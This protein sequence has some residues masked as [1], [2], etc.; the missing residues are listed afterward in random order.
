MRARIDGE[1]HDTRCRPKLDPQ[2]ANT[3]SKWWSTALTC[4]PSRAASGRILRDRA[5]ALGGHGARGLTRMMRRRRRAAV[6]QP[7][8]PA[9]CAAT[10]CRRSSRACSRS[11]TRPAP[12]RPATVW[13]S[14][15]FSIPSASWC[16][17]TCRSPAARCAAGTGA[18][19][20][21]SRCCSHWRVTTS[22]TS[23][24]HGASWH[25]VQQALLYGSGKEQIE[26]KLR[27]ARRHAARRHPFEGIVPNLERRL[28]ETESRRCA[29]NWQVPRHPPLPRLRRRAPERGGALGAYRWPQRC[30]ALA[31]LTVGQA[32]DFFAAEAARLARRSRRAHRA[33]RDR[34]RLRFLV[35][36][37]LDYLSLDAA[38]H[39]VG[40]RERSVS[41]SRA[42]SAPGSPA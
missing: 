42:R 32:L 12:A 28:R 18:M 8:S 3:P 16:I 37:G 26:F 22:S 14:R 1:V 30:R 25:R 21:T 38:R 20:I 36:V 2:E 5:A 13:A 29:K 6:L 15:S 7:P 24:R 23:K 40:R 10:R 41:G 27:R 11:T 17:R 31:H 9:R 39:A 35:D 4:A 34:E 33:Q 19:R